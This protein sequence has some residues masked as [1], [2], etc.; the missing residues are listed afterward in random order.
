[1]RPEDVVHAPWVMASSGVSLY[2]ISL[3]L[4]FP[5]ALHALF[6]KFCGS[7]SW[8][9]WL[10]VCLTIPYYYCNLGKA[11][12]T[13]ISYG[14]FTTFGLKKRCQTGNRKNFWPDHFLFKVKQSTPAPC[15]WPPRPPKQGICGNGGAYFIVRLKP[16]SKASR[17][18]CA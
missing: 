15:L 18:W 6:L 12:R 7:Y 16:P 5:P 1:M 9:L 10:T 17:L 4:V 8:L 13:E 3:W 14:F 2:V 11:F